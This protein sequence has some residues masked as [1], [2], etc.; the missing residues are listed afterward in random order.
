MSNI[1]YK[2]VLSII[3][4]YKCYSCNQHLT[5]FHDKNFDKFFFTPTGECKDE[6]SLHILANE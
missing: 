4:R 6:R 1:F 2:L 3:Y 5:I